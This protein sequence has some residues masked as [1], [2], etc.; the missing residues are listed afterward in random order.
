MTKKLTQAVFEGLPPEYRWA[1]VD[2]DG[3]VFGYLCEPEI[4]KLGE[5]F[6]VPDAAQSKATYIPLGGLFDA[7]DWK[8]SPIERTV[9]EENQALDEQE[10]KNIAERLAAMKATIEKQ[11]AVIDALQDSQSTLRGFLHEQIEKNFE[12]LNRQKWISVADQLPPPHKKVL[13]FTREKYF[14]VY[15][16]TKNM[17]GYENWVTHWQHRPAPPEGV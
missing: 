1:A 6:C 13:V 14:L 7:T 8:K 9:L 12:L 4:S 10:H 2:A 15:A 16:R 5:V 17:V 11:A 3:Y